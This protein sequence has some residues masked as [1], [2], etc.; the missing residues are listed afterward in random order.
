MRARFATVLIAV[1]LAAA[2]VAFL[3]RIPSIAQPLGIDQGLWASAVRGMSHGQRLYRDVWEQRPPGIY[4]IYLAAFRTFG[5]TPAAVAWIDIAASAALTL[6]LFGVGSHLGSRLT[7]AVTAALYA[8][9]TM[10]AWLYGHGGLLERSVCETFIVVC[11]GFGAWCAI[12]V[13]DRRSMASAAGLGLSAG[14]AV[15]LKPNAG[16]YFP[17]LLVWIVLYSTRPRQELV[18]PIVMAIAASGVVPLAALL[19]LWRLDVLGDARIA[20]IDFNRY[21]VSQGYSL[22]SYANLFAH[23]LF[24][25]MKT[26]PLWL[27]GTAGSIVAVW[28]LVRARRLP[29]LAGLGVIWGAAAVLVIVVNGRFLFNS[30]FMNALPPMAIM[31]GW[32]LVDAAPENRARAAVAIAAGV[33]V[34]F[35]LVHRG[36]VPRVVGSARLDVAALRG[37]IDRST[38]LEQFGGYGNG[39][40][41]SARANDELADY[42]RAHTTPDERIFLFG[43]NGAGV[44]FA[45][46]R[47]SAHRFLR[48]NDFVE[49]TFPDPAFRLEAVVADLTERRPR[50]LI[51]EKLN[52]GTPMARAV[53]G[54]HENPVVTPLL[55]AYRR[56]ATIEDFSLYRRVD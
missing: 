52:T 20:V 27:A 50:Y 3:L 13:R 51:F 1:S 6:L 11:V 47:L 49:T 46:D 21:Y 17:A 55:A 37:R 53:D 44:Y 36:Y 35:L 40:G 28:D 10:P 24:L 23:D 12:G 25:R 5:W 19:W 56:E 4:W 16:L 48:A 31:A 2:A 14:A 26:E 39:R 30:Y 38:Y 15:I 34:A 8:T 9:L 43:I 32:L 18:R 7:G 45:A 29:P 41:Y 42:V 33:A 22:A 54:L